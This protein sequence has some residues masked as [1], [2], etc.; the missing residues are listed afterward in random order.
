MIYFETSALAKRYIHEAETPQVDSI[1]EQ[2]AQWLYTSRVT[3]AEVL[4]L[5]ARALRDRRITN[6]RYLHDKRRFL[7]EWEGFH[8]VDVTAPSLVP[9]E[10]LVER[11]VLR[12]FDTVHLSAALTLGRPDFACFDVRLQGAA[13]AEG[14]TII[15]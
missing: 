9:A 7:L 13:R 6:S 10:R 5:L 14:L 4:S 1:F 2:D 3:Y 15:P 8:V 11:H 12:G